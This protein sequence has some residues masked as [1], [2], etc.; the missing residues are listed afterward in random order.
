MTFSKI[1]FITL[2]TILYATGCSEK[3]YG[4]SRKTELHELP[5]FVC[6]RNVIENI[7]EI[8]SVKERHAKSIYNTRHEYTYKGKEHLG[9]L[10]ITE[11]DDGSIGF[12]QYN[13][14]MNR[15][16]SKEEMK[17]IKGVMKDIERRV[18]TICGIK[19][20][21]SNILESCS[22]TDCQVED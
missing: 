4:I 1:I 19:E 18:E 12:F 6:I 3:M 5:D 9:T 21:Q 2:L 15:K 7:P 20:L 17:K 14:R 8:D 11:S 22:F 16:F 10:E 13:M